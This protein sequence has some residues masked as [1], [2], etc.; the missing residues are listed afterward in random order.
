MLMGCGLCWGCHSEWEKA[1]RL[2]IEV[3][4]KAYRAGLLPGVVRAPGV[5]LLTSHP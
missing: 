4:K 2:P 5:S 3:F 1:K